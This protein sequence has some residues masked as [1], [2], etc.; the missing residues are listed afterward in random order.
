MSVTD[1][2]YPVA[3]NTITD[4]AYC[5]GVS[6]SSCAFTQERHGIFPSVWRDKL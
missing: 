4:A 5:G 3:K 6:Y 1:I 2:P